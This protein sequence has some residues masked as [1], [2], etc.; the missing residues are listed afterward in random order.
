MSVTTQS[1]EKSSNAVTIDVRVQASAD[2][3]ANVGAKAQRRTDPRPTTVLISVRWVCLIVGSVLTVLAPDLDPVID[4]TCLAL[5]TFWTA[6]RSISPV[7]KGRSELATSATVLFELAVPSAAVIATGG[8][9]SPL[10]LLLLPG[11]VFSAYIERSLVSVGLA[12]VVSVVI[13][14]GD[15]I[16][17]ARG[18][19]RVS[20]EG[21]QG[22]IQLLILASIA[23]LGQRL[24][25]RAESRREQAEHE[26]S[27]ALDG[28]AELHD[29]NALLIALH[30]AAQSL[31]ASLDLD[32]VAVNTINNAR[33]LVGAD[34]AV[35]L[36]RDDTLPRWRVL[37][38]E[39]TRL[40]ESFTLEELPPGALRCLDR[41]LPVCLHELGHASSEPDDAT[42]VE[43][44]QARRQLRA[45]L[46]GAKSGM[47]VPLQSRDSL[48]GVLAIEHLQVG[49]DHE[50]SLRLITSL[51]KTAASAIDNARWFARIRSIAADEERVRIARDLHDRIGQSLA[52]LGFE[53]ERIAGQPEMA[54]AASELRRLRQD[55]RSV[56][57]EVR[58]T[59]YQIRSD[60]E[61]GG[62]LVP[63]LSQFLQ[64]ISERAGIDVE[65]EHVDSVPLPA[66]QEREMW[67]IAQEALVNVER[68]AQCTKVQVKW[69]SDGSSATL[70]VHDNGRGFSAGSGRSDSYGLRGLSERAAAIGA[71]LTIDSTPHQG[72][73]I[74]CRLDA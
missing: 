23:V 50:G 26:R 25:A 54:P 21:T 30:R 44:L 61:P 45:F 39:G 72:T 57:T 35:V 55:V 14:L 65:F 59:L 34:S 73:R 12:A 2:R 43:Q 66:R 22:A 68:H 29:A 46:P 27:Q 42:A 36:L 32:D 63:T 70:E 24:V 69:D 47:Y 56:V 8:W 67:L 40:P 51:A 11:I 74:T 6:W 7:G 62:S 49:Q 4:L 19:E 15:Y 71:R 41:N 9:N 10:S 16:V 48:V 31:P 13:T 33:S 64:R 58:E 3:Q 1:S 37:R 5:V 53:L 28:V 38:A 20:R 52:Y 18:I 17:A 60:V